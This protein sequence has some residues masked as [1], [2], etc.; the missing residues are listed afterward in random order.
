[1]RS[2]LTAVRA[3][4][5]PA[6]RREIRREIRD[7]AATVICGGQLLRP[8]EDTRSVAVLL[9]EDERRTEALEVFHRQAQLGEIDVAGAHLKA[10]AAFQTQQ[11]ERQL[12]AD[13]LLVVRVER[14][15]GKGLRPLRTGRTI[16]VGVQEVAALV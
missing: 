12:E 1:M 16:G 8:D 9:V 11:P 10:S 4:S 15:H 5:T 13:D 3:R 14:Q 7:A 2:L 6:C